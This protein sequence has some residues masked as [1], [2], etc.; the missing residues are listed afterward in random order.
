MFDRP[1]QPADEVSTDAKQHHGAWKRVG[2][3]LL[4]TGVSADSSRPLDPDSA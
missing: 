4:F 3:R 1:P 2:D